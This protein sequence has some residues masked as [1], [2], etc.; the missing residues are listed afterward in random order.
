MSFRRKT[1]RDPEFVKNQDL[2]KKEVME[3]IAANSDKSIDL[4]EYFL[5]SVLPETEYS[6]YLFIKN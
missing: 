4:L 1:K 3:S 5:K 2:L 6:Y